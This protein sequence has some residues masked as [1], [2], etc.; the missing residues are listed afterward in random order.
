MEL[1]LR[2]I[3]GLLLLLLGADGFSISRQDHL[4]KRSNCRLQSSPTEISET[5]SSQNSAAGDDTSRFDFTSE[6]IRVYIEDTDAYGIVYN[7]NYL[8]MFDRALFQQGDVLGN[9]FSIVS[10]GHEKFVSSPTLGS[11]VVIKGQLTNMLA[12]GQNQWTVWNIE[13]VSPDGRQIYNVV[14]DLV[15]VSSGAAAMERDKI[16][17]IKQFLP[18]GAIT[19]TNKDD[20]NS[21]TSSLLR[22]EATTIQRDELDAHVPNQ[23]PLRTILN[24]FERSRT[25][26]FGGPNN[27]RKLQEEDGILAVVTSTRDLSLVWE[28]DDGSGV[29][30]P[31]DVRA[32]DVVEVESAVQVKPLDL[33]TF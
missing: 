22:S 8:R 14:T 9:D 23:L 3:L 17:T 11:D 10:V 33:N 18:K 16:D 32:G 26:L 6:P 31:V 5:S 20:R 29:L 21:P 4:K 7:S 13:M 12:T 24:Y 1:R 15:V 25:N 19:D 28:D 27:L 30:A 2:S